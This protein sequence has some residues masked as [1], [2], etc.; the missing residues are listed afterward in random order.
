MKVQAHEMRPS[1]CLRTDQW[2]GVVRR[3]T[4]SGFAIGSVMNGEDRYRPDATCLNV[5][6][7]ELA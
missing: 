7:S 2:R 6:V 1:A 3:H 4:G 5:A